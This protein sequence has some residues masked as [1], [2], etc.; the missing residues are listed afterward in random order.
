MDWPTRQNI[1]LEVVSGLQYLHE[2]VQPLI[3][4]RDIKASNILLDK[5]LHAKIA[6]FDVAR[7]FKEDEIA[8]LF[9]HCLKL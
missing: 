3:I 4:H 7:C 6:D 1:C 8:L 2:G 9:Q 5:D